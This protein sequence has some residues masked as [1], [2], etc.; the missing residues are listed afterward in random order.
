MGK[1]SGDPFGAS[2]SNTF[3]HGLH[4]SKSETFSSSPSSFPTTTF[5]SLD[6]I[7]TLRSSIS[8]TAATW[9][10]R[11]GSE[12]DDLNV[13]SSSG[14]TLICRREFSTA[15]WLVGIS[16]W[17]LPTLV[18]LESLSE[19]RTTLNTSDDEAISW[20]ICWFPILAHCVILDEMFNIIVMMI[21]IQKIITINRLPMIS[22]VG[23]AM[24]VSP[25]HCLLFG[26]LAFM[27]IRRMIKS[28]IPGRFFFFFPRRRGWREVGCWCSWWARWSP[29]H[30]HLLF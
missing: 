2:T 8:L 12:D 11:L 22:D 18:I 1:Y 30:H 17:N 26:W 7:W 29:N 23:D 16:C 27:E 5:S 10:T 3:T 6:F 15:G 25:H 4:K 21:T 13:C 24:A 28:L 14:S 20:L 9:S 19:T